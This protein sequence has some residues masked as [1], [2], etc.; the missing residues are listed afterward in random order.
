MLLSPTGSQAV[1]ITP[2]HSCFPMEKQK[3]KDLEIQYGGKEN[4]IT[5]RF[6]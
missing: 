1:P 3:M 5:L 6:R 4:R 2:H